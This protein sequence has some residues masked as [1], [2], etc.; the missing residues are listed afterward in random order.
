MDK[1]KGRVEIL[2]FLSEHMMVRKFV[3]SSDVY[4]YIT[5]I[6]SYFV[7]QAELEAE[8]NKPPT[9]EKLLLKPWV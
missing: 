4:Y 1:K 5:L 8:S 6:R 2:T 3:N 7:F 9:K